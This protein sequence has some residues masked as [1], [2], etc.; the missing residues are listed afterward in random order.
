MAV[1][2]EQ[3]LQDCGI[4]MRLTREDQ[5]TVFCPSPQEA[6][7]SLGRKA[8]CGQKVRIQNNRQ[9]VILSQDPLIRLFLWEILR[10]QGY[11]SERLTGLHEFFSE[12]LPYPGQLVFLDGAYLRGMEFNANRHWVQEFV[13]AG[14]K[15]VVL[16]DKPLGPDL[17]KV[18]K[19]QETQIL[20]KPLD[21]RQ[22]GAVMARIGWM[23]GET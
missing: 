15:L 2:Y 9:T 1:L 14:I 19:S 20:W 4:S 10:F 13:Q 6:M 23:L 11:E 7:G 8:M 12:R 16:A 22:V 3:S 21:Y 5:S 18:L 17:T